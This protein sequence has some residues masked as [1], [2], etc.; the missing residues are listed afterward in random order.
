MLDSIG[1][2]WP[3]GG[4]FCY[5]FWGWYSVL[6]SVRSYCYALSFKRCVLQTKT[7]SVIHQQR[8]IASGGWKSNGLLIRASSRLLSG[9][10]IEG[11]ES[12]TRFESFRSNEQIR[13][14]HCAIEKYWQRTGVKHCLFF[15]SICENIHQ[16]LSSTKYVKLGGSPI[17]DWAG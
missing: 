17:I 4:I 10:A 5:F 6:E 8:K 3:T 7:R 1:Q 14:E 2:Q 11:I 16:S 9:F 15:R 12:L 13:K